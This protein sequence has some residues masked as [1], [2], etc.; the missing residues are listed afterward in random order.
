VPDTK[1][2]TQEQLLELQE[3]LFSDSRNRLGDGP[4]E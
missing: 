4:A 1:G 3:R 2:M